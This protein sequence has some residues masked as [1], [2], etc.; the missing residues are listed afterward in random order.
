M[1]V[2]H[3]EGLAYRKGAS[4][5]RVAT[6]AGQWSNWPFRGRKPV[7]AILGLYRAFAW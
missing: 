1:V 7:A 5:A 2:R 3:Q 6:C 4:A